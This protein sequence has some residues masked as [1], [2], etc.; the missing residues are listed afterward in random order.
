MDLIAR[1]R[2]RL[3]VLELNLPRISG[4]NL[5]RSLRQIPELR[6]T[7]VIAA[8]QGM[9][10]QDVVRAFKSGADEFIHKPFDYGMVCANIEAL[11]RRDAWH[12]GVSAPEPPVRMGGLEINEAQHIVT[13]NQKPLK[14]RPMEFSLLVYLT[15]NTDRVLT[16]SLL[17]EQVWNGHHSM[18]TR[19]VDTTIEGL[20]RKL[21]G[22]LQIE[23]VYGNG[24]RASL[25][26]GSR[27][28]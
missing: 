14:L 28:R 25:S 20:R 10:A 15:N 17:L 5:L 13:V 8:A 12:R 24:Y 19:T 9:N 11:L 16:R 23:S 3:V 21:K 2:P 18:V 6:Q 26:K 7:L 27:K 22:T 4:W 1:E